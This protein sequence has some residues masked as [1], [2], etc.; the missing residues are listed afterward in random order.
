MG[1]EG[2]ELV[3]VYDKASNWFANLEKGFVLFKRP[4]ASD[5]EPVGPWASW[6]YAKG[7]GSGDARGYDDDYAANPY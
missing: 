2:W 5:A 7:Q 6:E 4:V 3:H 1:A